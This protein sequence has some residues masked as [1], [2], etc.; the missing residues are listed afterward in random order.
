MS[1]AQLDQNVFLIL[2]SRVANVN[3]IIINAATRYKLV[4]N[5]NRQNQLA[6]ELV[7]KNVARLVLPLL[8]VVLNILIVVKQGKVVQFVVGDRLVLLV[9]VIVV[10]GI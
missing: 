4:I 6:T 1:V 3:K 7:V 10:W 9:G 2:Y 8:F 5:K